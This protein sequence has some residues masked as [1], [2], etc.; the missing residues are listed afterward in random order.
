MLHWRGETRGAQVVPFP[1]I[2]GAA[3]RNSVAGILDR[4]G[5]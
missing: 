3:T 2:N 1:A 5:T 4:I